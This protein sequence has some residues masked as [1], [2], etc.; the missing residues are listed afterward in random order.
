TGIL[1]LAQRKKVRKPCLIV[2]DDDFGGE[3]LDGTLSA[4]QTLNLPPAEKVMVR[5]GATD[6]VGVLEKIRSSGCD[7]VALG[8]SIRDS[9]NLVAEAHRV[10]FAPDFVGTSALYGAYDQSAAARAGDGLYAVHTVSQPYRDDASK[11][12]RDWA[13]AYASEFKEDPAIMAVYGYYIMDLFGKAAAKAG[14]ILTLDSFENVLEATTFPRD[15]FGS[16]EFH[17]TA[18]DRLGSRKVRI[19]EIVNGRWTPVTTLLDV[20]PVSP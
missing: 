6:S 4:L 5:R 19:S 1:Y 15:I 12:V 7:L 11:L 9:L 8:I 13:A 10:G 18:T 2:Q 14:P 20:Q 16:P 17:V 3:V